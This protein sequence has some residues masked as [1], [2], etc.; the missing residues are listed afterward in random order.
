[1]GLQPP[2]KPPRSACKK[3][4]WV[5]RAFRPRLRHTAN[6]RPPSLQGGREYPTRTRR[7]QNLRVRLV[8]S[9]VIP[10]KPSF[11][12]AWTVPVSSLDWRSNIDTALVFRLFGPCRSHPCI[13]MSMFSLIFRPT[14]WSNSEFFVGQLIYFS[15]DLLPLPLRFYLNMSLLVYPHLAVQQNRV[16]LPSSSRYFKKC[17]DMAELAPKRLVLLTDDQTSTQLSYIDSL[18][19]I[20]VI[21][22]LL[23]R[24]S[25]CSSGQHDLSNS[26]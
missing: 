16:P 12:A 26:V 15:G 18:D 17:L 6:I 10:E 13:A 14:D 11:G 22:A 7:D 1:M 3:Y 23:C 21:R 5:F 20:E 2:V 24:C 19:H 8:Q 25:R 9:R 4:A